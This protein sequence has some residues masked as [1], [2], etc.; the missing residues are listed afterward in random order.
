MRISRFR[1]LVYECQPWSQTEV[2][3]GNH[4]EGLISQGLSLSRLVCLGQGSKS[5]VHHVLGVTD[6]YLTFRKSSA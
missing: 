3:A 1:V 6:E 5:L 4:L 2:P